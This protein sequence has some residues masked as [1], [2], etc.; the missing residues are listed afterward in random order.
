MKNHHF[1]QYSLHPVINDVIDRLDFHKPT[2]I[3]EKVIPA[4]LRGES[5][6]GQSHTG[7]GKTHAYLLPLFNEMEETKKQVQFVVTAPTRELA[8]Q[9]Y[10]EVRKIIHYANKDH[11]WNAKLL[12][13][14]TDKKRSIEKLKEQPHI[15]VGTPGRILDLVEEGALDL[16][17][18]KAFVVDEADLML[19]L[20]FIQEVD[21]TLV[22]TNQ[23][24]QLLVFSA[25]IPERLQPF[26]KKYLEN[27]AHLTADEHKLSPE[28]MEHRLVPLRHRSVSEMVFRISGAIQPYLAIIFTNGKELAN[29]LA[30]ELTEKGMDVGL[31]HGGLSPRERKRV[32]KE[33]QNL[34]YQ[35]IVAT[36]LAARGIDIKGVSHVI[37]AQLPKEEEFY[38]HRVGRTARAG[39][40]GTAINLYTDQDVQLIEKLE[41]KGL[42]FTS[43]DVKDGE[44]K[45]VKAWNE[46]STRKKAES[47]AEKEA[48]RKVRKP[49]KVK[50]GYKKKMK[51]QK[52]QVKKKLN[53]D[54]YKK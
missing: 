42:T 7:S 12:I 23:E 2:P 41:K 16:Y 51:Q 20:G 26:L 44:W 27:P 37:N 47:D 29:Q 31:I 19:D 3:Q 15:V 18:A 9:I 43:F 28:T 1:R 5:V 22:K 30:E 25:T 32:L 14:G 45:E 24:I 33:I 46:R 52:E 6:I 21:K 35:Y 54:K 38:I 36:D 53:R 4:V 8:I 34:R 13:G 49:K 50:P 48:W 11:R 40:E 39:M 17:N 10:D